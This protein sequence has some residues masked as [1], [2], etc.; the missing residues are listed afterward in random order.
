M[1]DRLHLKILL[2]C[3]VDLNKLWS[4]IVCYHEAHLGG[5]DKKYTVQFNGSQADGLEVL[6]HCMAT[7]CM[8][9][10]YADFGV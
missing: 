6:K 4:N 8:G 3:T 7:G 5:E 1:T 9:K 2:D 10:F